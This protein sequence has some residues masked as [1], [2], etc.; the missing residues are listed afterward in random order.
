MS[1]KQQREEP[2]SENLLLNLQNSMTMCFS[3]RYGAERI[4]YR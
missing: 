2:H 1:V 3:V 4:S